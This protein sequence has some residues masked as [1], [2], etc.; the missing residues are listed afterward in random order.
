MALGETRQ[1]FQT[2]VS[3]AS[4]G[5]MERGTVTAYAPWAEGLCIL[6]TSGMMSGVTIVPHGL[7]LEDIE[8]LNHFKHPEYR[9]RNVSQ[10]GS[11]V[12]VA[13]EGEFITD[14]VETVHVDP[15]GAVVTNTYAQGDPIYLGDEGQISKLQITDRPLIGRALSSVDAQGFLKVFIDIR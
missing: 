11:V 14:Q 3:C 6:A 2:D 10:V 12:G 4:S 15:T 9:N 1:V 8:S 5:T 13:T 7:L